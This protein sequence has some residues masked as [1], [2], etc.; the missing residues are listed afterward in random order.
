MRK[1]IYQYLTANCRTVTTWKQPRQK[2][3]DTAKPFGVIV[4]G[5]RAPSLTNQRGAFQDLR[6]WVH[7]ELG[8]YLLLDAAIREVS[9]LL[10]DRMLTTEDGR[11]FIL[12]WDGEGRDFEDENLKALTKYVDFTIPLGG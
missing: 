10:R 11:R 9:G 1:A 12:E 8:S 6:V 3:A 4:F 5:E 2:T 7:V